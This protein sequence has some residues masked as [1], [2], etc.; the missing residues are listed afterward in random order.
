MNQTKEQIDRLQKIMEK[1]KLSADQLYIDKKGKYRLITKDGIHRIRLVERLNIR[2]VPYHYSG[3][4]AAIV[5]ST[6][7][8]S[9]V[10]L[11]TIG[12]ANEHNNTFPYPA[13]VAEKRAVGRLV[14]MAI[15]EHGFIYTE[16]EINEVMEAEAMQ[17]KLREKSQNSVD[18]TKKLLGIKE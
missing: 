8:K 11:S 17:A 5:A 4:E 18:E 12:E 7:T 9:G 14:L 15:E 13:A 6:V 10:E 16:D 3:K 2:I 1:Y